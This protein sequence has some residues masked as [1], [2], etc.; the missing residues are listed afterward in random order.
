MLC[1][2]V[3]IGP[4]LRNPLKATSTEKMPKLGDFIIGLVV[5]L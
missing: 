2:A 1:S 3:A 5:D 4:A